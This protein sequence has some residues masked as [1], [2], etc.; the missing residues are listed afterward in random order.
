MF[1]GVGAKIKEKITSGLGKLG[2][3]VKKL[4]G[5]RTG[6]VFTGESAIRVAEY[7]NATT[8]PEVVTPQ[9]IM[10]DTFAQTLDEYTLKMQGGGDNTKVISL[11]E[12]IIGLFGQQKVVL[13]TGELVGAI[14]PRIDKSLGERSDKKARGRV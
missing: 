11:L 10:R 14:T 2:S 6:G 7:P 13:S 3:G 5:F 1:S 8:N 4:L 12:Q 9:N